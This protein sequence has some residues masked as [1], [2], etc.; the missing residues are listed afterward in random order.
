LAQWR[1]ETADPLLQPANLVRLKAE[2]AAA[3]KKE[4]RELSWQY[5]YYFLGQEP[6]AFA[7]PEATTKGRKKKKSP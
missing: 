5:P 3:S 2:M 1:Q 6:P 4:A 7:P